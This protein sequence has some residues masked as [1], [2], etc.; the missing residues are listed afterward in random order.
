MV[1]QYYGTYVIWKLRQKMLKEKQNKAIDSIA[2]TKTSVF[3]VTVTDVVREEPSSEI[4]IV[5][6]EEGTATIYDIDK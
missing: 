2:D 1:A 4:D 5:M 3:V 6:Q